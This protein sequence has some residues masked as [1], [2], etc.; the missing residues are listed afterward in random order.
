MEQQQSSAQAPREREATRLEAFS[1][2]V[3]AVIITIM[4]LGLRPPDGI[5]LD[6]L[7]SMIPG[8]LIY[9]L[10]FTFI[11]IYWNNHHHLL[12]ATRHI[13]AG[14][15]WANLHLLFWLSLIPLVTEWIGS[16]KLTEAQLPAVMYGVVGFM[17][18]IAFYIL[19]LAIRAANKDAR[20]AQLLQEDTRPK[21]S[22]A[23]YALGMGLAYP[24]T[25]LAYVAYGLVSIIWF[26]PDGRYAKSDDEQE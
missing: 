25:P 4:V 12:R 24:V 23:L 3:L 22:L 20:V 13:S 18:G 2:G 15:M 17:A 5:D 26:I 11:G 21:L 6:A 1:D 19:T 10:S 16:N 14:V 9:I 8:L 7:K